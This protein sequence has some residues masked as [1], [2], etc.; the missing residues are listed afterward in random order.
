MASAVSSDLCSSTL[1]HR[2]AAATSADPVLTMVLLHTT[3]GWPTTVSD[4]LSPYFHERGLLSQR[5]GVLYHGS[6]V[7]V[8][9]SMHQEI[10]DKL[11]EGH[12]G[13]TKTRR[14]ASFSV[15]WPGLSKMIEQFV[16]DCHICIKQRHQPAETLIPTAFPQYP[17]SCD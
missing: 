8:P 5:K 13:V 17:A 3:H 2:L 6:R 11:H 9:Q 15:W 1:E 12:Q 14:R 10:L 7:V 16:A 4:K